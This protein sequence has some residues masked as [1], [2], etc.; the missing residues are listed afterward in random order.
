M[1]D[2]ELQVAVAAVEAGGEKADAASLLR[3]PQVLL[4]RPAI[5]A[6]VGAKT[7]VAQHDGCVGRRQRA[8][9]RP[10]ARASQA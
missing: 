7:A 4:S 3:R 9:A 6:P 10:V 8:K 2:S 5:P 1:G